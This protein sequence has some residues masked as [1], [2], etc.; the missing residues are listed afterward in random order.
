MVGS[1]IRESTTPSEHR[2]VARVMR[3]L[4]LI[5]AS[6][7]RGM[8]LGELATALQAPKSSLHALVKGL[9]AAG[10]LRDEGARYLLGPAFSSLFAGL[11]EVPLMG[12]RHVLTELAAE[13]NETVML[14]TFVGDSVVYVD[15]VESE[16]FI[17]AKPPMNQ[18]LVLWPRSAGK[19]F[20]SHADPKRLDG[21]IRRNHNDASEAAQVRAAVQTTKRIGYGFNIDHAPAGH[22]GLAVALPFGQSPVTTALALA[23]PKGRI[24]DKVDSIVMSLREA[25][26]SLG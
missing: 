26:A 18:R 15:A 3:I 20:L 23:G 8:R 14:A 4:E 21:Y 7:E 19:V 12:I 24:E 11:S 10:Y 16:S 22:I 25:V 5:I 9:L 2:T 1:P 17:R 6:D 13:W